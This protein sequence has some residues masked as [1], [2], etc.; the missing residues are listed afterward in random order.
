MYVEV[1]VPRR[2][3]HRFVKWAMNSFLEP[4]LE[5]G[6]RL[7]RREGAFLHA[8]VLVVDGVWALIGSSN[9]DPRSFFLNYELNLGIVGPGVEHIE[10]WVLEQAKRGDWVN[11][12]EFRRRSVAR[13]AW[14]NFWGLFRPLL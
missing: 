9:V 12:E 1:V 7:R 5:V 13:R 11:Y 2:L 3:D 14:E 6:V 10:R 4:L 8:K